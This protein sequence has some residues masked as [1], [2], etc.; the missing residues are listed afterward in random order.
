MCCDV[1]EYVQRGRCIPALTALCGEAQRPLGRGRRLVDAI[2]GQRQA[3]PSNASM[4]ACCI[5]SCLDSTSSAAARTSVTP[6]SMRPVRRQ[7]LPRKR[8]ACGRSS[9]RF[10][11]RET[12]VARSSTGPAASRS[13]LTR[14][15]CPVRCRLRPGCRG[16]RALHRG[17]PPDG[18]P[19]RSPRTPE[20]FREAARQ[21]GEGDGLMRRPGHDHHA[22]ELVVASFDQQRPTVR[23]T[24]EARW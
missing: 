11:S 24:S 7:T 9:V 6:S 20:E 2:G 4:A 22:A 19:R 3:S 13:P 17:L 10:A 23:S 18:R 15:A 21:P 8:V 1:A 16:C 12:L 14:R 5:R